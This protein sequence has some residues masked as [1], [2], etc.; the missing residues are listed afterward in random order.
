M[1][2]VHLFLQQLNEKVKNKQDIF[3]CCIMGAAKLTSWRGKGNAFQSL[4]DHL[5]LDIKRGV[6]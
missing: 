6:H 4:L 3:V 5:V 1:C 2:E